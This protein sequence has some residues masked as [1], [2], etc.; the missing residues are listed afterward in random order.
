MTGGSDPTQCPLQETFLPSQFKGN[1]PSISEGDCVARL[2]NRLHQSVQISDTRH[3]LLLD[4]FRHANLKPVQVMFAE[5]HLCSEARH[6]NPH[7]VT[8]RK[9]I[10]RIALRFW[11]RKSCTLLLLL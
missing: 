10:M 2:V 4:E 1:T 9:L 8:T 3:L 7:P 6:S 11:G 5:K